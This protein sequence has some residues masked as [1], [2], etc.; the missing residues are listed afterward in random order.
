MNQKPVIKKNHQSPSHQSFPKPAPYVPKIDNGLAIKEAQYVDINE[1][2]SKIVLHVFYIALA[3]VSSFAAFKYAEKI[4]SE[5]EKIVYKEKIV[6]QEAPTINRAPS[7]INYIG[8]S[9]KYDL[10]SKRAIEQ[11]INEKYERIT[12]EARQKYRAEREAY[13]NMHPKTYYDDWEYKQ[14]DLRDRRN[15]NLISG[16]KDIELCELTK[17]DFACRAAE[18]FKQN[19]D[20]FNESL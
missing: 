1:R 6:Y 2:K 17:E 16:Q 5:T 19:K 12:F 14:I 11:K 18:N 3:A 13:K 20:Q 4:T 9:Y 8:S 7:S 10:Y 15:S